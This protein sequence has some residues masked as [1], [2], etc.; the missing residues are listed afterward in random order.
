MPDPATVTFSLISH[1]N[2]GKTTLAR[3]LLRRDVGETMDRAHV[4][5]LSEAHVM[6][7]GQGKRLML[8]DTPGFGDTARLVKRLRQSDLP[9]RW[10]AT[11]LWD[12]WVNRSL[13]CSQ[14]AV[15]NVRDEA[16][17]V[18]YLVDASQP[19]QEAAYVEM[20][21]E[22]LSWIGK[23]V[24]LLLNQTGAPRAAMVEEMDEAQW[25]L[26]LEKF[27]VV[28]GA[29]SLDAFAR[30]W[31][32]ESELL[33]NLAPLVPAEKKETYSI[34]RQAWR[35]KNL[36]VH[37]AAVQVLAK[38]LAD[39]AF[40]S[41]QAPEEN[42]LQKIGFNRAEVDD[43]LRKVREQ[44]AGRLASR[45]L[46]A[47]DELIKLFGLEGH[48]ARK[49]GEVAKDQFGMPK[50]VNEPLITAIAGLAAGLP[51]GL[52]VDKLAGG[53][54]FGGG[55]VL[56]T[57]GGGVTAYALAK[58][59]NLVKANHNNVRWSQQHF[60]E[61][62]QLALLCYLAVS[63][64]GRGRGEWEDSEHPTHW[65]ELVR[66]AVDEEKER[67][68]KAWKEAGE[69]KADPASVR[70]ILTGLLTAVTGKVLRELYPKVEVFG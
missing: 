35:D 39:S 43:E 27:T 53:F 23:P 12:R 15:K 4:T 65:Q 32:Q 30:C 48:S 2:V 50:K 7:A 11:Q 1:T 46:T 68:E 26:H 19:P 38:Q 52:V 61:Q 3:T 33:D 70:E 8:W 31:V 49:M 14:Q 51:I 66:V 63:H 47:T 42:W 22:I 45:T 60:Y 57:I 9:I 18:L 54:T 24:M 10:M 6:V 58:G 21:M 44:L 59:F 13:W 40:D 55:A 16:D 69:E 29:L 41:A 56:G 20:E 5:D 34:L 64:F 67:V 17:V 62:V 37:R 28:K 36:T 25:R